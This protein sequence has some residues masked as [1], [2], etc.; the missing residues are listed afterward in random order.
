M[1]LKSGARM[2]NIIKIT[3]LAIFCISCA[4]FKLQDPDEDNLA[5][6]PDLNACLSFNKIE[7]KNEIQKFPICRG[8]GYL[9]IPN[10][11]S[12]NEYM[13]KILNKKLEANKFLCSDSNKIDVA[14]NELD[15]NSF[16]LF[17]KWYVK[18]KVKI[19][20][21]EIQIDKQNEFSTNYIWGVACSQIAEQWSIFL[22]NY[23]E[24]MLN[25]P[26]VRLLL[27]QRTK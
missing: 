8:G 5:I 1:N 22:N 26:E 6:N 27:T 17:G 23:L 3:F 25:H 24:E 21:K 12:L 2:I 11:D 4:N 9:S 13:I 14:I 10:G 18:S 15:Y 16:F 20:T 7:F 19:N